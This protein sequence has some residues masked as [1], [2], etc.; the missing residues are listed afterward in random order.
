MAEKRSSSVME[1]D[2]LEKKMM[3]EEEKKESS[4]EEKKVR[5]G[6]G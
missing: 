6:E 5:K 2:H 1:K 4:W 3:E